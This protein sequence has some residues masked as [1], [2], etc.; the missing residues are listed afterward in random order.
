MDPIT[1]CPECG[2]Q[3][4]VNLRGHRRFTCGREDLFVD[5]RTGGFPAVLVVYEACDTVRIA[6]SMRETPAEG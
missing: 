3:L 4:V 5:T 2:A 1:Q 6:A